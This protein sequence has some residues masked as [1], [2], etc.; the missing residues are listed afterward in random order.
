[1]LYEG[2]L[3][4]LRIKVHCSEEV[5]RTRLQLRERIILLSSVQ[6]VA[7][8]ELDTSKRLMHVIH[9]RGL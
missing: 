1:M 7:Q 3:C 2:Y 8:G 5:S 9:T 4:C 6:S